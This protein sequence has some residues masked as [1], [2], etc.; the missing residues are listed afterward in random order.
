MPG[1]DNS[2]L[3]NHSSILADIPFVTLKL[4]VQQI[5]IWHST[6]IFWYWPENLLYLRLFPCR[7]CHTRTRY[8]RHLPEG[9]G[10]VPPEP[11]DVHTFVCCRVV[12]FRSRN[13][14]G[15]NSGAATPLRPKPSHVAME[16]QAQQR[17]CER[18][19]RVQESKL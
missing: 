18:V 8:S 10:H 1:Q 2:R 16:D 17:K 15:W 6:C 7:T 12:H 19:E 14:Q 4:K 11:V 13:L 3:S 5:L 9:F